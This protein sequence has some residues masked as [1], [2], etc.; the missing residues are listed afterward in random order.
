LPPKTV[1]CFLKQAVY[2]R[3]T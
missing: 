1:K 2:K 3:T